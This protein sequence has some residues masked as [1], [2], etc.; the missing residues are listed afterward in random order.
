MATNYSIMRKKV[1]D[2]FIN[3]DLGH[4]DTQQAIDSILDAFGVSKKSIL[5]RGDDLSDYGKG[6]IE[7]CEIIKRVLI[8][9]GFI[10]AGLN[11]ACSL[12]GQYSDDLAA[13]WLGLPDEDDEIYE[14]IEQYINVTHY[15]E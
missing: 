14:C 10:N 6:H 9:N 4:I 12:W 15:F 8:K 2:V 1:E 5:N 3:Y 7:D 11:D 13:G